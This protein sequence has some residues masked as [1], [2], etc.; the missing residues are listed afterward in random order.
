MV[1]RGSWAFCWGGEFSIRDAIYFN[2]LMYMLDLEKK[3]NLI[4][5]VTGQPILFVFLPLM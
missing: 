4:S 3:N 5:Q 2:K 1:A